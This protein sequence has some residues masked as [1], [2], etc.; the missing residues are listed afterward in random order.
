MD[1]AQFDHFARL[2]RT[3]RG[4]AALLAGAAAATPL[5]ATNARK[6]KHKK[7]KKCAGKCLDG[8]C[9]GKKGACIRPAQ[10]SAT[11]CGT[12]GEICRTTGCTSGCSA[13][14]PCPAGQ[15]C[16]GDGRC[17]PCLVFVSST[18]YEG[19]LG[20]LAGAD[21][22]CQGL[23]EAAGKPGV[24]MAWLSDSTGSPA[25]RF[26][27]ATVPYTLVDGE[28]VANSYD[29]LINRELLNHAINMAET[30]MSGAISSLVWTN[31]ASD[32]TAR[33]DSPKSCADWSSDSAGAT[34]YDGRLSSISATW[35]ARDESACSA[36][37]RLFCFQQR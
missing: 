3:R 14:N 12:G 11:Q 10:Q 8:C 33:V 26:T 29:D 9:T 15:C 19:N 31:T 5:R 28:V 18:T 25:T 37:L 32:G 2:L 17:G 23:A 16:K 27:R 34:G 30:G 6:K 1:S 21:A 24:Y 13:S 22:I 36:T 7:K 20:G 35:T 4:I